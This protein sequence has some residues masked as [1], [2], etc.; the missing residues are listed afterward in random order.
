VPPELQPLNRLVAVVLRDDDGDLQPLL[1]RIDDLAGIEQERAV[2]DVD[3]HLAVGLRHPDADS[4]RQLV[5]HA[6]EAELEV[7]VLAAGR[8][9]DLQ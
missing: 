7:A 2:P 1:Q 6:G 8:V 4:R 3:V 5:A 9:P